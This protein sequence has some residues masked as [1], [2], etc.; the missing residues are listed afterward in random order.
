MT[1]EFFAFLA[2][3]ATWVA[4]AGIWVFAVM[5]VLMVVSGVLALFLSLF[6]TDEER[7][8]MLREAKIP[9][10]R[11]APSLSPFCES[12][13]RAQREQNRKGLR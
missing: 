11:L 3:C 8:Q 12:K 7:E 2:Q 10:L 5:V 6:M 4:V 9:R 1:F 13:W